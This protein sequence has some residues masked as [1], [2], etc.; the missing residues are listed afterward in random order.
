MGGIQAVK[1]NIMIHKLTVVIAL[2]LCPSYKEEIKK[3]KK[4]KKF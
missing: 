1:M 3:E 2:A 4:R